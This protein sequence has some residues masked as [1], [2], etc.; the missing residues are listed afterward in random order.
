[1]TVGINP[2]NREFVDVRGTELSGAHRR[3]PTLDSLD[4]EQWSLADG[5][6]IRAIARACLDYFENNPYRR[7]FDV[8]ERMLNQ[9]GYSYYCESRAAHL[10]LVAF[11]TATKWGDL[12]PR[13]RSGLVARGRAV[14]ASILLESPVE[15]LVLNGR[16]VV[17]EF[18]RSAEMSL[19]ET[20]IADWSLPRSGGDG[21]G[22]VRYTGTL[23]S[24]G[25]VDLERPIR[26]IGFNHNLQSSFG[27]TKAVSDSIAREVGETV[28]QAL[29]HSPG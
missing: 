21:V 18:L 26:V 4:L 24:V 2:S 14:L 20:T 23:T 6:D 1:M 3:L 11:A 28:A 17:R 19:E 29:T 5:R 25:G 8:L 16:A 22:G 10:D 7:W 15:V 13:T 27:V 12:D 9:G